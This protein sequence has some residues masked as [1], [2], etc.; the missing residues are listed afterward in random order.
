MEAVLSC[1]FSHQHGLWRSFRKH[2]QQSILRAFVLRDDWCKHL[3]SWSPYGRRFLFVPTS[4]GRRNDLQCSVCDRNP[5]FPCSRIA[6]GLA[7]QSH[8]YEHSGCNGRRKRGSGS[9]IGVWISPNC[10]RLLES[11]SLAPKS[12][13]TVGQILINRVIVE[14]ESSAE[15]TGDLSDLRTNQALTPK[16][17]LRA[18]WYKPVHMPSWLSI[19]CALLAVHM[20]ALEA[21]A[22]RA[23]R[24]GAVTLYRAPVVMRVLFG[25][26][27]VAMV[28]GAGVVVLSEDFPRDWWVS[29]LLLGIA[30]FCAWQ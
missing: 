30:V 26:A 29:V 25:T 18:L 4:N 12:A 14:V 20:F 16:Y 15:W 7:S 23:K 24:A 1:S 8:L 6:V 5:V 17:P 21:L 10:A 13:D 19:V 28:Y 2:T 11:S 27:I 22:E 9:S 3:F